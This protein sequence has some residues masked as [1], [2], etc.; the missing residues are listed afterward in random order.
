VEKNARIFSLENN[1]SLELDHG[2]TYRN[3]L[4]FKEESMVSG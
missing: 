3:S 4:C 2:I 1:G